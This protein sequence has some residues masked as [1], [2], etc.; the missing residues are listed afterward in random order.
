MA[1][2]YIWKRYHTNATDKYV[3][4]RNGR[5]VSSNSSTFW[6]PSFD[7]YYT[8]RSCNETT[9]QVTYSGA[10]KF[11]SWNDFAAKVATQPI[12]RSY[13]GFD[14]NIWH[15]E[16]YKQNPSPNSDGSSYIWGYAYEPQLKT[17]YSQGSYIEDVTSDVSNAYPTNGRGSDG[18]WYVYQGSIKNS[19]VDGKVSVNGVL[20]D[21][22]GDGYACVEGVWRELVGAYVCVDRVWRSLNGGANIYLMPEGYTQL[23]Y[24][25]STGSQ[26]I[27]SG[28]A[29]S[30][31]AYFEIDFMTRSVVG[32]A[33]TDFGTILGAYV[34]ASRRIN[35]G[36]WNSSQ[37]TTGGEMCW[38]SGNYNPYITSNKRMQ[39]SVIGTTLT[40]PNGAQTV[41]GSAFNS[42]ST[43][44]I[45]AR[46]CAGNPDQF[47]KTLLYSL[48]MYNGDTL[49]RDYIPCLSNTGE[50]G[51]WDRANGVFYGNDGSGSL[52]AGPAVA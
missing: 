19:V 35:L 23:E 45:F 10:I 6:N 22:T 4:E 31:K 39:V 20:K 40:T 50:A 51:L 1:I 9:G 38:G 7:T 27:D 21:L 8:S 44:G 5:G 28:V 14:V 18:Y 24:I 2:T 3:L 29:G 48:K 43:I 11:G 36:T 12:Y 42:G 49:I 32:P 46:N 52:V 13:D 37:V 17:V 33:S 47:S 41:S 16:F 34:Q 26:W 30:E 15:V 25:E